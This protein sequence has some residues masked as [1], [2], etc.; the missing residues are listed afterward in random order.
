MLALQ[1]AGHRQGG[2]G[3]VP[4]HRDGV[5]WALGWN[6]VGWGPADLLALQP[7]WALQSAS[8]VQAAEAAEKARNRTA[9]PGRLLDA[10]SL[11]WRVGTGQPQLAARQHAQLCR[12]ALKRAVLQAPVPRRGM[13]ALS[14]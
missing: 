2:H 13:L 14:S 5:S 1:G 12:P 8:A 11:A 6:E 10:V 9:A 3:G 4:A 7:D